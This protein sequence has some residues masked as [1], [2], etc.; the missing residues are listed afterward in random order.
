MAR[1]RFVTAL[2]I[3][4]LFATQ[5]HARQTVLLISIDGF[6]ADY[7]ERGLTPTLS[8]LAAEGVRS[9]MRPAF[10]SLTFPNHY[11]L[12]TGLTPDHHGVVDNNM[13]DPALGRFYLSNRDAVS[14]R[15]WWD[16]GTPLWVSVERQG[17]HA[18]T[19]FWPGA[20][21]DIQGVRPSRSIPY[22]AAMP[23][24]DR[25]DQ[26]LTWLDLPEAERPSFLTLY[27]EKVDV[28]AHHEGIDTPALDQALKEIDA[29]IA[30]LKQGLAQRGLLDKTDVIIVAD[31]GMTALS[32]DRVIFIDDYAAA[33]SI[34]IMTGSSSPMIGLAPLP[35][36]ERVIEAALLSPKP[37]MTCRRKQDMLERFHYGRNPRVPPLLCLADS[38]WI[39]TTHAQAAKQ[40]SPYVATHG[41]D[42]QLP[43][44]RAL[45]IGLGPDFRRGATHAPFDNV[46]VYPL[47]A[48]LLG[49]SPEANDGHLADVADMLVNP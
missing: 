24:G 23:D 25:V 17:G 37:H 27:F 34:H 10:P 19:M 2:L 22:S 26:I 15:R 1:S 3:A 40:Q 16:G 11:S 39:I 42:N 47:I 9:A 33:D 6:R 48:K 46:D 32:A 38:G 28:V 7:L 44:M 13:E 29:A 41:F 31:H 12:V 20:D 21:A 30:R 49:I 35:G 4:L 18:A 43:E 36:T 45:F 8:S 14:D 5:A